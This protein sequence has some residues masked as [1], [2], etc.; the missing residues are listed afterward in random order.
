[1]E[2]ELRS[3]SVASL[4]DTG[5]WK[6]IIS[7]A[8]NG[9]DARLENLFTPQAG[10]IQL[11]KKN[12]NP[13]EADVLACI[14]GTIYDNPRVLDDFATHIIIDTDK[15][16]WIPTSFTDEEDFDEKLFTAVY[17]AEEEDIFADFGENE[18]C[19]YTLIPGLKSFLQR[20]LP[21]CRI[22]CRLSMLKKGIED[23]RR[24]EMLSETEEPLLPVRIYADI[25]G[26]DA[27][28]FAYR[29]G[30]FLCGAVHP[31]V[32]PA[33]IAYKILLTAHAY[34]IPQQEVSLELRGDE[35]I[36]LEVAEYL[37]ENLGEIK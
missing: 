27:I 31:W 24:E 12:W 14:E 13:K 37:Q 1:M 17:P 32:A 16:L 33:D 3:A 20:T 28:I 8:E 29:N 7:I 36:R 18:V 23:R 22:S 19:V 21:G 5:Q 9:M 4:N 2:S 6:L 25:I 26:N 11:F 35:T 34:D 10:E 30:E 15:A